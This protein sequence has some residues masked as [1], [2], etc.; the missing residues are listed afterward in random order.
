MYNIEV[1]VD[2]IEKNILL[3]AETGLK[4][5]MEVLKEECIKMSDIKIYN[6]PPRGNYIRTGNYRKSFKYN[7]LERYKYEMTNIIYYAI[8]VEYKHHYLVLNDGVFNNVNKVVEEVEKG[9]K[10]RL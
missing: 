8:Y 4:N 10:R 6:T 1:V 2:K 5:G 7:K 3:G 9:I